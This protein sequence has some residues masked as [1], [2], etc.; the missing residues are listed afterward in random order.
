MV[1]RWIRLGALNAIEFETLTTHLAL[2][3]AS[4]SAP[5]LAWGEDDM[6][7]CFALIAPRRL[8]PGKCARWSAWGLAPAVATYRQFDVPAY[9]EQE[10][11]WL[12]GRCIGEAR[13]QSLGEC[14][15]VGSVFL[16]RFPG[17]CVATPSAAIEEAFRARLE[18]QHGWQF[19]N[20]WPSAHERPES[21]AVAP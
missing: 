17:K 7:Y 12:H 18:A 5:V 19:D 21:A 13:V 1:A 8:A 14:V 15:L 4:R 3:Q 2:A 6:Q 9:F 20:S 11:V 16:A 10:G